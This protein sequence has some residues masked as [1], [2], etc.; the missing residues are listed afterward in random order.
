MVIVIVIIIGIAIN[1]IGLLMVIWGIVFFLKENIFAGIIIFL[2]GC[3]VFIGGADLLV[4]E[5]RM[6]SPDP[7]GRIH[8]ESQA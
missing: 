8:Q 4:P 6:E 1:F 2:I 7:F 3:G 5:L